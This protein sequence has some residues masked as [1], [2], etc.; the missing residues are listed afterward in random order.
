MNVIH[1][2]FRNRLGLRTTEQ[3]ITISIDRRALEHPRKQVHTLTEKEWE[4]IEADLAH[5]DI[6]EDT[7][8]GVKDLT[9]Q[10]LNALFRQPG[11]L[12]TFRTL[13]HTE[14]QIKAVATAR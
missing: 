6:D 4:Q 5:L 10:E 11:R 2:S 12:A 9:D 8:R 14:T 13:G 1:N 7:P 3:L